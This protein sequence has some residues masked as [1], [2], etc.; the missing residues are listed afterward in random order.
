MRRHLQLGDLLEKR[1]L[2][3]LQTILEELLNLAGAELPR[4]QADVVDHQQGNLAGRPLVEV[5]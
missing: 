3:A 1:V 5:R 2:M 4:R